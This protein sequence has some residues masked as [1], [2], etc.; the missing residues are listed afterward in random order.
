VA[1]EAGVAELAQAAE[2]AEA[3]LGPEQERPERDRLAPVKA[4]VMRA[5][6]DPTRDPDL[7]VRPARPVPVQTMSGVREPRTQ[8]LGPTTLA[9]RGA[10]VAAQCQYM[11]A[12]SHQGASGHRDQSQ[13]PLG[14]RLLSSMDGTR[15]PRSLKERRK[16]LSPPWRARLFN[17]RGTLGSSPEDL[18]EVSGL[19]LGRGGSFR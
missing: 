19:A 13:N 17:S 1:E 16:S 10:D 5:K 6:C 4:G 14:G 11:G 2:R 8:E 7:Q 15:R 18:A 3:R 9:R 12:F